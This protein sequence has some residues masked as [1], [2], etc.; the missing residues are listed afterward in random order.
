[1]APNNPCPRSPGTP[2]M[3]R[4]RWIAVVARDLVDAEDALAFAVA[5]DFALV[6]LA[7]TSSLCSADPP[8]RCPTCGRT[9]PLSAFREHGIERIPGSPPYVLLDCPAPGCSGTTAR[10][11]PAEDRPSEPPPS[12]RPQM[13]RA[14]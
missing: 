14:A 4:L 7:R 11:L 2:S 6:S 13:R 3:V 5:L 8:H 1:M 10:E 9:F 12:S